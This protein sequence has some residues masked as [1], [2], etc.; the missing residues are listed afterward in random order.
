M[1]D[2]F[3]PPV[4]RPEPLSLGQLRQ[5]LGTPRAGGFRTSGPAN[6]A[7]AVSGLY[8][9]PYQSLPYAGPGA[10]VPANSAASV[11]SLY[12]PQSPPAPMG[13]LPPGG[14][15]GIYNNRF[16]S[17]QQALLDQA[18]G[19]GG[20]ASAAR[21]QGGPVR[22]ALG[23]GA[24]LGAEAGPA[25]AAANAAARG[26]RFLN[27]GRPMTLP[28]GRALP[29][30]LG[31]GGAAAGVARGLGYAILG[32]AA[33]GQLDQFNIGGEGSFLDQSLPGAA[34]GAGYGAAFG[35]WGAAIGAGVGGL[36]TGLDIPILSDL[37]GGAGEEVE[38]LPLPDRFNTAVTNINNAFAAS[39]VPPE[40]IDQ[41]FSTIEANLALVGEEGRDQAL[42]ALLTP[43]EDGSLPPLLT[44]AQAFMSQAQQQSQT[45][46][47]TDIANIQAQVGQFLQPYQQQITDTGNL[48]AAA[49]T[50]PSN[51]GGLSPQYQSALAAQAATQRANAARMSGAIAAQGQ[52][53]PAITAHQQ[54]IAQSFQQP[55]D[56]GGGTDLQA[57]L[58]ELGVG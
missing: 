15:T 29:G 25:V 17:T 23:S 43:G 7:A 24:G 47:P 2:I 31:R 52:V 35:P 53:L 10:G 4:A 56:S 5:L 58:E 32:D 39:G 3:A 18:V 37:F 55:R 49:L 38:S 22:P 9:H 48:A 42:E 19:N 36:S 21:A 11:G 1:S 41:F 45:M 50:N 28:G 26:G 20:V 33:A 27:P 12:G 14:S 57:L 46:T 51:L 13:A 16:L 6:T 30:A 44:N 40:R 34:R 54:A 8:E